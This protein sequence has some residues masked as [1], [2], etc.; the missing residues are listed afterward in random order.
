MQLQIKDDYTVE[1]KEIKR[2]T[3]CSIYWKKERD[4]L[5]KDGIHNNKGYKYD[6][7]RLI[8]ME[9]KQGYRLLVW[10]L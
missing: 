3:C 7:I 4:I 10:I 1:L 9:Y 8:R 2:G 6:E 5:I